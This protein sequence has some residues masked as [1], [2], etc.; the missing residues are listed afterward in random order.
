MKQQCC[1]MIDGAH[2]QCT[3][4]AEW[5]VLTP[6]VDPYGETYACARHLSD[7][8]DAEHENTVWRVV[9]TA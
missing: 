8:L 1:A 9:E 7:L 3:W 2:V 6:S 4:D 5:A